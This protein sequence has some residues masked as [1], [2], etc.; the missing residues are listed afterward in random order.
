[1]LL[2]VC[3]IDAISLVKYG[4][5]MFSL[6]TPG[7]IPQQKSPTATSAMVLGEP[8][9]PNLHVKPRALIAVADGSDELETLT[10]SGVLTRGGMHVNLAAV[11]AN[12]QNII[13]GNF[14]MKIQA[15]K[16][17]DQCSYETYDLIVLPGVSYKRCGMD[18]PVNCADVPMKQGAG[19]KRLRDSELLSRMLL[20]QQANNQWYAAISNAPAV[21]L[22]PKQM[23]THPATCHPH[24]ESSMVNY[25][26]DQ[27]VVVNG[28]C[29]TCQGAGSAIKFGLRL[30]EIL[31]G[32]LQAAE[33][34]AELHYAATP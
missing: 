26:V 3:K 34:A 19:A 4:E 30:V 20:R 24:N 31:C 13:E 32:E 27:D 28:R 22:A 33:V 18:R 9:D 25:F 17:I 1:M 10:L 11:G 29:V 7:P 21:I 23:L 14:G 6:S 16:S 12:K 2:S 8:V 15:E 5:F